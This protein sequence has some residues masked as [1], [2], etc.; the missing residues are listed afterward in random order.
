MT[1]TQLGILAIALALVIDFWILRTR[2]LTRKV[3][4]VS[5]SI[6]I[7]FQLLTNGALTGF[8]IVRY[9]GDAII[10]STIPVEQTPPFIGDG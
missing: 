5:Y 8:G 1:Y 9:S 4:W 3:F 10:G 6:I 7:C 2:L